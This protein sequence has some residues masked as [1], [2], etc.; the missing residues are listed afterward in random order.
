VRRQCV[1]RVCLRH[2]LRGRCADVRRGAQRA[3]SGGSRSPA[4]TQ[5]P[6]LRRAGAIGTAGVQLASI[7]APMSPRCAARRTWTS[8]GRSERIA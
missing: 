3:A 7:S 4:R 6:H 1:S 2:E 5:D 8:P